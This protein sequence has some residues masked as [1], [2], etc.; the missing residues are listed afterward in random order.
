MDQDTKI[1]VIF[2]VIASIL[3]LVGIYFAWRSRTRRHASPILP[4]HN[5][6]AQAQPPLRSRLTVYML[7]DIELHGW[8][9]QSHA[10]PSLRITEI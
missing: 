8:L 1:Q 2:G 3:A 4:V 5:A 7:E 10:I 9:E 6:Q